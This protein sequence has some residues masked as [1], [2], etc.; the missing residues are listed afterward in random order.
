LEVMI[1]VAGG[2]AL[3]STALRRHCIDLG[4]ACDEAAVF[5]AAACGKVC[6]CSLPAFFGSGQRRLG[7]CTA[8]ARYLS[9]GVGVVFPT[10]P[11]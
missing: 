9:R 4:V 1:E 7:A 8:G 5:G 6:K 10:C 11:L 2:W 3:G